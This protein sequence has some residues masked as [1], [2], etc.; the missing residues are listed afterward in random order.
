MRTPTQSLRQ[1]G[2]SGWY[3]GGDCPEVGWAGLTSS[4]QAKKVIEQTSDFWRFAHVAFTFCN[5]KKCL[6]F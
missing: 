1:K 6:S 2:S 5:F 3:N 4:N